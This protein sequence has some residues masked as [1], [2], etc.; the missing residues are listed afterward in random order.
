MILGE[1]IGF[2]STGVFM[3]VFVSMAI[4]QLQAVGLEEPLLTKRFGVA[5]TEYKNRVPRWIPKFWGP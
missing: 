2:S 5:Y 1:A 3:M 4:A